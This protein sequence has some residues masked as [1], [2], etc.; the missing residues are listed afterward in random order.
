MKSM[1]YLLVEG[2]ADMK[3]AEIDRY[4]L[5]ITGMENGATDVVELDDLS[6]SKDEVSWE[7]SVIVNQYQM[8]LSMD[9]FEHVIPFV[10]T[11]TAIDLLNL[12]A[13]TYQW[14]VAANQEESEWFVGENIV[15]DN[16]NV[17]PKVF[18]SKADASD[19]MFF[20]SPNGT[21]GESYYA[22]HTGTVGDWAGTKEI[23]SAGGK[24]RI[25]DLFFG[26]AD[27]STLYLTD[28]E[29]GD[30]LFLDDVYTGLPEEIRENTAR[31]F[32]LQRI[33][34]GAGDDIIDMTSQQFEYSGGDFLISGGDGDDIIWANRGRNR[35][36]G[37]AGNDRIVGASSDDVIIGG[38][39][40]DAMHGGGGSDIFTFC[41][42]WGADTVEQLSAGLVTLW[43]ASG[44]ESHW[45]DATLTYTDGDNSVSVS[46]IV[47]DK[48]TLKFGDDGSDLYRTLA[49]GGSFAEF[50]SKRVFEE[51]A[52]GDLA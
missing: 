30:A 33:A 18:Q 20:A 41:D 35:L 28:L 27:P 44:D 8:E 24:G 47:A 5:K 51:Y 12:P 29:N 52:Q 15:S 1:N 31:L 11:G 4:F 14:R 2:T 16:T 46:G 23:V 43:F 42:N 39:G 10:T 49:S 19:D 25:Q 21:W 34:A 37:D 36:F 3:E 6:G 38:I 40:D 45:D 7:S 22:K 17:E 26:S 32:R 50:S 48:V 9:G 13:G